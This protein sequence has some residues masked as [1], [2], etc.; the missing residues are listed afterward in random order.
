MRHSY[1]AVTSGSF[2]ALIDKDF[3]PKEILSPSTPGLTF[4]F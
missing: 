2:K 4:G 1:Q 3:I